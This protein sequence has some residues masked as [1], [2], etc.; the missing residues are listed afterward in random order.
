[1]KYFIDTEFIEGFHKPFFGKR[2]HYIDLISIGIVCEDGREYYAV[3]KEYNYNDASDWVKENVITQIYEEQIPA[4]KQQFMDV[5][6]FHKYIP[7]GKTNK[8][9]AQE[10]QVFINAEPIA[11]TDLGGGSV[12]LTTDAINNIRRGYLQPEFYGY[13]ADYD[14][15]VFCSLYGRMMD[16]PKGF[17]MYCRDLKQILDEKNQSLKKLGV[18]NEL[19]NIHF[20]HETLD[21]YNQYFLMCENHK[22]YPKQLN[23]H[24][25]LADAKWNYELY[26]FLNKIGGEIPK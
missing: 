16:L 24:N 4:F 10:I 9:I 22:K 7:D 18:S 17:P 14:W 8:Q 26:K 13:Y 21:I 2:R 23:E 12:Q 6:T 15:V 3:S 5:K 11:I 25:A 19:L 20:T 1:M